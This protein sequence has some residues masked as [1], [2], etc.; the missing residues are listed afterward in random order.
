M[1]KIQVAL[2]TKGMEQTRSSGSVMDTK[3]KFSRKRK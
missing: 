1:E 3:K 2:T